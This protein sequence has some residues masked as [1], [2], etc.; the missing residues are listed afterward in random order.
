MTGA[1]ILQ[2]IGLITALLIGIWNMSNSKT[3]AKSLGTLESGQY[4]ESVNRS[5]ELANN[6]ALAAEERAAR[7]EKVSEDLEKR[8]ESL[9]D[10]LS[11]RLTFDVT[12]G[13]N[14]SV[15]NVEIKHFTDR[16]ENDI[17]DK[18]DERRTN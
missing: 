4:L 3:R 15:Q 11:Y 17:R 16:R 7:A 12:L 8:I 9:E 13:T 18:T 2:L 1:D 6:R 14:P 10:L 5:I